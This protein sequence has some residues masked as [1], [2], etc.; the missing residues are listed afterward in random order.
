MVENNNLTT[1]PDML[2]ALAEKIQIWLDKSPYEKWSQLGLRYELTCLVDRPLKTIY[3]LLRKELPETVKLLQEDLKEVLRKARA[4]SFAELAA[5]MAPSSDDNGP[6]GTEIEC[7]VRE[8]GKMLSD[9]ARHFAKT[10]DK[11]INEEEKNDDR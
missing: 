8:F 11:N 7:K 2:N 4:T 9:V 1:L 5:G 10:T 3:P 6:I